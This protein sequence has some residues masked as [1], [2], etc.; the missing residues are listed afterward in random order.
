MKGIEMSSMKTIIFLPPNGRRAPLPLL[1][2][3]LIIQL[4]QARRREAENVIRL[5]NDL[6]HRGLGHETYIG[7]TVVL[8]VQNQRAAKPYR[9]H[10]REL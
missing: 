10:A 4:E 6:L 8:A 5:T 3:T 2:A 1:N 7:V 9:R